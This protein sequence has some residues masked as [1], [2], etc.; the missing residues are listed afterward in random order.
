[1]SIVVVGSVAFDTVQT[2]AGRAEEVLGGSASYFSVAASFF[3]PVHL[4]AVVGEDFGEDHARIFRDRDIDTTGL[5]R[6]AGRTFRWSG[7]YGDDINQR[8]TL[9]T[10]LNVF[11]EFKPALPERLRKSEYLFLANIDPDLQRS[12]LDQMRRPRLVACDTMNFWIE[13]KRDAV[14]KMLQGVDVLIINDEEAR[15][16][17]L[18]ANTV[19]AAKKILGYGPT[20]LIVKRGEYG[21]ALYTSRSHFAVPAYPLLDPVDPTGAGD[22]F[23]GGFM[24]H[25]ARKGSLDEISIRQAL[26]VGS[27]MASFCVEDFSLRRF[28]T[29]RP[30]QI[31]TRLK[32]FGRMT[33]FADPAQ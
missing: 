28:A 25:L 9:S 13:G 3:A 6:V 4:V 11:Q 5:S 17:A 12:V 2:P 31:R 15:Q 16:L 33:Q 8:T 23:A 32:E 21:A 27:V 14:R 18:E 26:V 30:E 1:M 24:G 20:S 7:V 19:R 10:E 29:L 22:S